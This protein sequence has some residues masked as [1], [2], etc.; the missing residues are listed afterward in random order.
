M[1]YEARHIACGWEVSSW[2]NSHSDE[3]RHIS[4]VCQGITSGMAR[5]VWPTMSYMDAR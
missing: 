2:G 5:L 4:S 1:A 3:A